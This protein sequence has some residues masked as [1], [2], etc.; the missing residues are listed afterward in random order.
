MPVGQ[1]RIFARHLAVTMSWK[2]QK[3]DLAVTG[4]RRI[5]RCLC[6]RSERVAGLGDMPSSGVYRPRQHRVHRY[7][8]AG[9]VFRQSPGL[10]NRFKFQLAP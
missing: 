8:G 9:R 5:D 7:H 2:M 1:K 4:K 10:F 6:F 3:N